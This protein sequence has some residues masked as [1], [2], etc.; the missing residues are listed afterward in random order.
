MTNRR[1]NEILDTLV[2]DHYDDIHEWNDTERLQL[3]V[4]ALDYDYV[5]CCNYLSR[6]HAVVLDLA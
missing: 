2:E 3:A 5:E 1:L 6:Q 4:M